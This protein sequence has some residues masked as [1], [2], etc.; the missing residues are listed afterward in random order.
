MPEST[1]HKLDRVRRPRVQITYD[2]ETLGSIVKTELPFVVGIMADLS[3]NAVPTIREPAQPAKENPTSLKDRKFVEID[4]D[5]FDTIMEKVAPT[6]KVGADELTFTKLDDFNPINVLRS[7]PALKAKFESRTRL[8]NLVAKLD[9]NVALQQQFVAEFN[10]LKDDATIKSALDDYYDALYPELRPAARVPRVT[11]ARAKKDKGGE[12]MSALVVINRNEADQ[13][14]V[15]HFK[16]NAING[17]TLAKKDGTEITAPDFILVKDGEDGLK[18]TL[19]SD[20]KVGSFEVLASVGTGDNLSAESATAW[21]TTL[22]TPDITITPGSSGEPSVVTIKPNKADATGVS[23][24]KITDI[25]GGTLTKSDDSA[26]P[27][28]PFITSDEG[29]AG[30]KFTPTAAAKGGSFKIQAA[31]SGDEAGVGSEPATATIAPVKVGGG[32]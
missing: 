26:I 31:A 2:V 4:R 7:V 17:G 14:E 23:H 30:L 32:N 19:A 8:S 1:Q 13:D 15:S 25:N 22:T 27:D 21:V 3:G 12:T 29:K 6:V 28:P 20:K 18:F 11:S 24:F 10:K 16:I 9:G 5:N